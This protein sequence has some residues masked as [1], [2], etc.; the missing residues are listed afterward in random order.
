[1]EKSGEF[2]TDVEKLVRAHAREF[3]ELLQTWA[4]RDLFARFE[5]GEVVTTDIAA[6]IGG[7]SSETIRRRC[8]ETEQEGAPI[9]RKEGPIWFV[10]TGLLLNDLELRGDRHARLVAEDRVRKMYPMWDAPQGTAQNLA[11]S[12]V[13]PEALEEDQ[14][15]QEPNDATRAD[16]D[17]A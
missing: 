9:G 3:M 8:E 7:V 15:N 13:L 5:S 4:A 12:T 11:A 16:D 1:M 2:R 10:F 14:P 6:Q 17:F